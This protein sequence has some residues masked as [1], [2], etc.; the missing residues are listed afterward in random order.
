MIYI[1]SIA[2][3]VGQLIVVL[4]AV[5]LAVFVLTQVAPGDAA[6]LRLGPRASEES[7]EA[8]R[9]EL[10]LD[11]SLPEQYLEY[12]GRLLRGDLG[13]S[14]NGRPVTEIIAQGIGPTFWLLAGTLVVS[15]VSAIG[16]A[17]VAAMKRDGGFDHGLRLVLLLS[18][19]L[20]TFW[21]GFLL[22]R[23]IAIPTGW[24]PV[25]GLG[26]SPGELFASLV[27]PSIAGAI[28]LTPILARSLRSSLIDVLDSEYVAVA[29]SLGI[30]GRTLFVDHVIRNAAGPVVTLLALN[31]AYLFFGVVILEWTFDIGG[32]GSALITAS[33]TQDVYVVQGITL[34]FAVGVVV[35]NLAGELLSDALDPR[36]AQS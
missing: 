4:L 30:R 16:I 22:L 15:V 36:G 18:L 9:Q 7:V 1:R 20:P 19:F 32:L 5:T 21:V 33:T 2:N 25:G 14:V 6:R 10:G 24:F 12:L 27:L 17:W 28:A 11:R 23:F 31:T 29:R 3:R 13:T 34:L 35:A 8:L 26:D